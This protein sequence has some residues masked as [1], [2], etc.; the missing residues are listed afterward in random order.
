MKIRVLNLLIRTIRGQG[1][2]DLSNAVRFFGSAG[3]VP[4]RDLGG[5]EKTK[6][7]VVDLAPAKP[8]NLYIEGTGII[9][10]LSVINPD[11]PCGPDRRHFYD[12]Q[13]GR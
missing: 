2:R 7:G 11:D 3:K 5:F 12:D 13:M 4:G 1:G 9:T 10:G 6:S 8:F